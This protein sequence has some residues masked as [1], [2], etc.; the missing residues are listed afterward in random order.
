MRSGRLD[1][2]KY[3]GTR[4]LAKLRERGRYAVGP[5]LYL[6]VSE[7]GTRSWLMRY[8]LRGRERHMGLG[9]VDLVTLQEARDKVHDARRQV[10][11]GIDP[12][13]AKRDAERALILAEAKQKTFKETALAYIAA[14]EA[15]WKGDWSRKQWTL[16]LE[17][18]AY[19]KIGSLTVQQIDVPAVLSV[20]E[21]IWTKIPETARRVRNRIELVLDYATAKGLRVGDNPARW[22]GLLDNLLPKVNGNKGH[23]AAL[24]YREIGAFMAEL[25]KVQGKHDAHSGAGVSA[26]ALELLLLTA[27]RPNEAS[28]A[29]G[30]K[31][32]ATSGRS[33]KNA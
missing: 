17:K 1:L 8:R 10:L 18:Y 31:L 32:R 24:P 20:V 21:P 27:T 13:E 33:P 11:A 25:R 23:Y 12:L 28:G 30:A 19:P 3:L 5:N 16:S 7:T 29:R 9:P 15:G 26:R 2:R 14:H 22:A 4:E 6:Q